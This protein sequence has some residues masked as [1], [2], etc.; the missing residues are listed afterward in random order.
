MAFDPTSLKLPSLSASDLLSLASNPVSAI[1]ACGSNAALEELEAAKKAAASK[2]ENALFDIN[3]KID[4]ALG[5]IEAGIAEV[6]G[7][8]NAAL[9][10]I[11]TPPRSLQA[12]VTEILGLVTN[13]LNL[14]SIITKMKSLETF[15]KDA[16]DD[17]D[18]VMNKITDQITN[19]APGGISVCTLP[20]AQANSDGI[21]IIK[22]DASLEPAADAV[23]TIP[24]V[25][26]PKVTTARESKATIASVKSLLSSKPSTSLTGLSLAST[27]SLQAAMLNRESSGNYKAVNQFGFIGGYQMG[28]QSLETLGYLKEG[29]SKGGNSAMDNPANWTGKGGATSKTAFL[30][31]RG[32]QDVAFNENASF[33]IKVLT[34]KGVINADTPA[35]EVAGYAAASHLLG[36]TGAATSLDAVDGNGVTGKEY[37]ALGSSAVDA[38][39]AVATNVGTA[40]VATGSGSV[41][42]DDVT[43]RNLLP[44]S[45][46][47]AGSK[48]YNLTYDQVVENL[49]ALAKDVLSP[50]KDRFPDMIITHG[51]RSEYIEKKGIRFV[52]REH[53]GSSDHYAG[54]AADF[55][56]KN[57]K[58]KQELI[59]RANIIREIV[60]GFKQF[61]LE[62]PASYDNSNFLLH[63]AYDV[64]NNKGQVFTMLSKN[65][66]VDSEFV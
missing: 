28:A 45:P 57:V 32:V 58:T 1:A 51:F 44:Y 50:I 19:F 31:D 2:L 14:P 46:T 21:P 64:T 26:Q 22:Q 27:E 20:N 7:K 54:R 8:L 53:P 34:Q 49:Q 48:I 29:A 10:G 9:A 24:I 55:Q 56:F 33:N 30:N 12:D 66:K 6:E 60:P 42:L 3:G 61:I 65:T 63:I 23:P 13:P 62:Y 16:I 18:S 36:P 5:D 41:T 40:P 39:V 25:L 17:M 43:F 47:F 11:A 37:F 59:E 38:P 15:F 4:S 52:K 35:D